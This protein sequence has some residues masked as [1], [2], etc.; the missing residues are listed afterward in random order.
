MAVRTELVENYLF[1]FKIV[2]FH[3][4]DGLDLGMVREEVEALRS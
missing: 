3:S 4:V 2:A 1:I